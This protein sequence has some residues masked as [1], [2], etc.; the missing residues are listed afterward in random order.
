MNAQERLEFFYSKLFAVYVGV[1]F[2]LVGAGFVGLMAAHLLGL[3]NVHFKQSPTISIPVF[4]ILGLGGLFIGLWCLSK[5]FD[6][7]PVIV[8]DSEGV[9]YRHHGE[10][11]I[12]WQHIRQVKLV[13][14]YIYLIRHSGP[15][16][17]M[18]IQL[19]HGR[20]YGAIM[21]AWQSHGGAS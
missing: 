11:P 18:D 12:P 13:R 10:S 1:V 21:Q 9:F 14:N 4:M 3:V 2:F 20:V 15:R 7:R 17:R 8:V 19:L 5:A 16:V 6:R